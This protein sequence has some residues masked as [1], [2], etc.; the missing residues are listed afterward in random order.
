[1][2]R[3]PVSVLKKNS[4]PVALIVLGLLIFYWTRDFK[5]VPSGIGPAFFPRIV[6]V[7]MIGLSIIC[8]LMPDF[9][10]EEETKAGKSAAKNI[11]ITVVSLI[12]MVGVMKY[13]HPVLGIFLFLALYLKVIAK[14]GTRNTA[15]ITVAGT[16]V[17][18]LVI[19]ILRI[20][21]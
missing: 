7:M 16:A 12:V 3:N 10:V 5:Q 11:V 13:I 15:V 6:A 20:P 8:I 1:M 21:M 2:K 18:Y 19:R 9:K 14:S 17:L 4:L